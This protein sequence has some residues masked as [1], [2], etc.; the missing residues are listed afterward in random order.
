VKLLIFAGQT[1]Y[2]A[3]TFTADSSGC[4]EIGAK[5]TISNLQPANGSLGGGRT[6]F[7][8]NGLAGDYADF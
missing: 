1:W 4:S 3:A 5:W 2:A 8:Y 6:P 7:N